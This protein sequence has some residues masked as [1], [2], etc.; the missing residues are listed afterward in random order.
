M[1]GDAVG[2]APAASAGVGAAG[3]G[4]AAV[5]AVAVGADFFTV[6]AEGAFAIF[7]EVGRFGA[8]AFFV[9]F[10]WARA[11]FAQ[12]VVPAAGESVFPLRGG[13]GG[14]EPPLLRAADDG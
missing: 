5:F 4:L 14:A 1:G 12:A 10:R 2:G 3:L 8:L 7:P 13:G 6:A 9:W 11:H